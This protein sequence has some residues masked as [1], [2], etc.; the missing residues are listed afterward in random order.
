M[1]TLAVQQALGWK[2]RGND[3]R[4]FVAALTAS[5]SREEFEGRTICKWTP[6]T[7]AVQTDLQG[8]VTGAQASLYTRQDGR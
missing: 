6:R 1:A 7:Y 5:F 2:P 4:G 8:G 3:A